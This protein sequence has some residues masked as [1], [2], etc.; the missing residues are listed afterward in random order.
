LV[1]QLGEHPNVGDIRGRGL[2]LSIEFVANRDTKATFP[3]EVPISAMLD[4]A[5]FARGV[6]AYSGFGKGTADGVNGDHILF[7][8]PLNISSAE[9]AELV[10]AAK[11]AIEEVFSS[12]NLK[13]WGC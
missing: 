9:I 1:E 2:F 3:V 8:P 11:G 12:A 5:M 4:N 13:A 7:S 6:S 10:D